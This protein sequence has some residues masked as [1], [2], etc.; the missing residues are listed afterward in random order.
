MTVPSP[1]VKVCEL[2]RGSCIGCKRTMSEI[3]AWST[4]ADEEKQ[5]TLD[6][7]TFDNS[8]RPFQL[9]PACMDAA[10]ASKNYLIPAGLSSEQIRQHIIAAGAQ[11]LS[12]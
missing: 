3:A 4:A 9:D 10:L 7:I 1:C 8:E 11:R 5:A 6:R 2:R 12:P